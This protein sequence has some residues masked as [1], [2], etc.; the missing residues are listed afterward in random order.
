M[1][2]RVRSPL[3]ELQEL[4]DNS[5]ASVQG[6]ILAIARAQLR[7]DPD[8]EAQALR[9]LQ[10]ILGQTMTL[11][12]L[13]GRRRLLLEAD[14]LRSRQPKDIPATLFKEPGEVTVTTIAPTV[15]NVPFQEAID[16]LVRREP[17]L[18]DLQDGTPLWRQV[19]DIY[20]ERHAFAL[21]RSTNLTLTQKVQETLSRAVRLGLDAETTE[22]SI[23]RLGPWSQ[24]YAETVYRTNLNTAFTAGRFRQAQDPDVAEVI[25]AF[26]FVAVT[27]RDV[28]SNHKAFHG[29]IASLN[30]PIWE[31]AS[32]PLGYNCRCSII[33]VDK[34]T[35]KRRGLIEPSGRVTRFTPPGFSAARPD[36][37]FE[38]RSARPDVAI[39]G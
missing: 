18:A 5:A 39:Y 23:A 15:P 2:R 31:T 37:G 9:G 11:A 12:D 13:L 10:R 21:A 29:L 27:D 32:P 26:E 8:A 14:A 1:A 16:D 34:F 7:G 36:A 28:R 19:A 30:D 20:Q 38:K 24:S 3:D 6:R 35:L 22:D 4:A 33:M 25:G 17:R